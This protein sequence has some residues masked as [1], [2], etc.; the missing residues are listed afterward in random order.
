MH[1]V[2]RGALSVGTKPAPTAPAMP[3]FGWLLDDSQ[4]A[5]VVTY[6]RNAGQLGAFGDRERRQKD[7]A[8]AGRAQRL[9]CGALAAVQSPSGKINKVDDKEC[10]DDRDHAEREHVAHVLPCRA[11]TCTC[12]RQEGG[13]N[14]FAF[15]TIWLWHWLFALQA[16]DDFS[17]GAQNTPVPCDM[18]SMDHATG[19]PLGRP[20]RGCR[21]IRCSIANDMWLV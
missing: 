8:D 1:V 10:D 4:V 12:C 7:Q 18:C 17:L 16:H 14:G 3:Q 9:I 13:M 5:A 19:S 11:L 6:I 2:L 21:S 15:R 20:G